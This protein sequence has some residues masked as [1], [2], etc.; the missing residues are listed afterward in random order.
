VILRVSR[1]KELWVRHKTHNGETYIN[2]QL[3]KG[4]CWRLLKP[5]DPKTFGRSRVS[6]ERTRNYGLIGAAGSVHLSE[7]S[8]TRPCAE[9]GCRSGPRERFD[10]FPSTC[11]LR[12][13]GARPHISVNERI[14]C[15]MD[16]SL[17]VQ[18]SIQMHKCIP[19]SASGLVQIARDGTVPISK[20]IVFN[21][22]ASENQSAKTK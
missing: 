17:G 9:A 8:P 1:A 19:S 14:G 5:A 21:G 6:D 2:K 11:P 3:Q 16:T 12:S 10:R 15:V 18:H 20:Q 22:P 7:E 4:A 13:Q